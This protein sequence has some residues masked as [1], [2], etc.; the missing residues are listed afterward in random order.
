MVELN[1]SP[2]LREPASTAR[3]FLRTLAIGG[4]LVLAAPAWG[5]GAQ[6]PAAPTGGL[7]EAQ[8]LNKAGRFGEALAILRP[9]ASASPRHPNIR[10]LV[11]I[12]AIGASQKR[13]VSEDRRD[14]L[15]DE[16][17]AALRGML[18]RRPDLVRVRLELARAFFLKGEDQVARRH[19]EQVLADKPPAAVALNV[20]RFLN[21]MRARKRW[22]L[23]VGAALLPDSNI[24]TGSDQRIIYINGLPFL[25]NQEQLTTSGVG[26]SAWLGGEYQYPLGDPGT[27][28]GAS[29]WRL[30]A[31]G[32]L[33]RREYRESEFDQMTV[34]GHV[35]PRW[36]I[37]RASEASLLL[38]GLHHWTGSG[39]EEPSH[40]D[41]GLRVEGRHRLNRRTTVTAR[42]SRH[43]RRYDKEVLRD[44]P[45]TDVS[46]GVR[47]VTSP[48]VRIDASAG[49][50]RERT[51]REHWRNSR[52]WVQLGAT[53]LL[54]WGFTVGG[55]GRLRWA[56][57][58]GRLVP[59]HRVR[60]V[61]ERPHPH[62]PPVRAQPGADPRRVQPANL[63]DAGTA[64]QQRPVSIPA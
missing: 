16:A 58:K 25:R 38:S 54:P 14:E 49:C 6:P 61:A 28:S 59:V 22:S 10:F 8:A 3:L 12:A 47:W 7:K 40:H 9:L 31:G 55:S 45:I 57:Y 36:L 50:G 19:F 43:E 30:R 48:T 44:G 5:A 11:G 33:S 53:A 24:G 62:H 56:D 4:C 27:G 37:G 15:L 39:F 41:I 35:G 1:T 52:R 23:R 29:R 2:L 13:G 18:V 51:E 42:A 60:A 20:N 21:I 26:I 63:R 64:H 32:D 34:S 17:I 46:L